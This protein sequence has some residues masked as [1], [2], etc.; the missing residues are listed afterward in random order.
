M[1][2]LYIIAGSEAACYS[3]ATDHG[4]P[5]N[6]ITPIY[7][8]KLLSGIKDGF[9]IITSYP[10]P[11]DLEMNRLAQL[12]GISFILD[13]NSKSFISE[14]NSVLNR[15]IQKASDCSISID[16]ARNIIR[17]ELITWMPKSKFEF[18]LGKVND[19][20]VIYSTNNWTAGILTLYGAH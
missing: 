14:F 1:N 10:S 17:D 20:L 6:K 19:K 13:E 5:S 16:T 7:N 3:I 2:K 15:A 12:I 18:S 4:I 11:E 9:A 8:S